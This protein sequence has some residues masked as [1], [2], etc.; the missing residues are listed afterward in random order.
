MAQ[1]LLIA[2]LALGSSSAFAKESSSSEFSSQMIVES[3]ES[4][5]EELKSIYQEEVAQ[6]LAEGISYSEEERL[7]D[8]PDL[9]SLLA[10][11]V[12]PTR[13]EKIS[14]DQKVEKWKS[15]NSKLGIQNRNMASEILS[16][17]LILSQN[18]VLGL[19]VLLPDLKPG[20]VG[21]E[22]LPRSQA[23]GRTGGD[24]TTSVE[25]DSYTNFLSGCPR[26][27][28]LYLSGKGPATESAC[29]MENQGN[30]HL[31]S[32]VPTTEGRYFG[33][34]GEKAL[35]SG[36]GP[37][38]HQIRGIARASEKSYKYWTFSGASEKPGLARSRHKTVVTEFSAEKV[39]AL[40]PGQELQSS[41][42]KVPS[43]V[44]QDSHKFS[45]GRPTPE[46]LT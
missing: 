25:G 13:V 40:I 16:E 39:A 12:V 10:D 33:K 4:I 20:Q 43:K 42:K 2:S 31:W 36:F 27:F 37:E 9:D 46:I 23:Q 5:S 44:G 26:V 45:S 28:S 24:E 34:T 17:S 32:G 6:V 19:N 1:F 14:K 38:V 11:E 15:S 29:F 21:L 35:G 30:L 7:S 8:F 22:F 3:E 41:L 18:C